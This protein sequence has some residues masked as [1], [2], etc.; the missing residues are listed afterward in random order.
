[1]KKTDVFQLLRNR[2]SQLLGYNQ[3]KKS[4]VLIPLIDIDNKTHILFEVRSMT[5]RSQPGDICFPGGRMDATDESPK[6]TAIRET[7]E[8]LG[9][10]QNHVTD[11]IPLDYYVGE[12]RIIYPFIGTIKHP[13]QITPFSGEVA[14]IFTVPLDFFLTTK[15]KKYNVHFE[16]VPEEN[17][18]FDQIVGGKDYNWHVQHIEEL[19]YEY[20]G[21]VIWGLTAKILTHFLA[22]IRT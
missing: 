3:Y 12:Q 7:S 1:M 17:F 15:P 4:A 5:L 13:E 20:E 16:V 21:R 14:E 18:P 9:I 2:Q 10:E 6:H 22:L 19:F 8:E 11:V